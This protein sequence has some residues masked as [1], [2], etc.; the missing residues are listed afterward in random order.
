MCGMLPSGGQEWEMC[1]R[2]GLVD[3]PPEGKEPAGAPA[4]KGLLDML[5]PAIGCPKGVMEGLF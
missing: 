1:Y 3:E 2:K 4:I 5:G